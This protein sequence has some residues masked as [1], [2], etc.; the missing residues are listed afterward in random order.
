MW[1]PDFLTRATAIEARVLDLK[2]AQM[3][4]YAY[5]SFAKQ[6][7]VW[8]LVTNGATYQFF[9]VAKG[10]TLTYQYMPTLSLLECD[11]ARQLLQVLNAIRDWHL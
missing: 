6:S 4:S 9:Y 8:G 5:T 2:I 1:F 11:R 7:S 3:L 10:E